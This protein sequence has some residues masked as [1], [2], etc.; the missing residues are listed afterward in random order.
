MGRS[1]A[2]VVSAH[3]VLSP[4]SRVA[5]RDGGRL[6]VMAVE[7]RLLTPALSSSDPPTSDF[8]ATDEERENYFVGRLPGV[9]RASQP[10]AIFFC[11][12]GASVS[13]FARTNQSGFIADVYQGELRGLEKVHATQDQASSANKAEQ[14]SQQRHRMNPSTIGE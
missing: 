14:Q 7:I 12:V 1:Q 9:A 10:R 4:A 3:V 5:S 6:C 8:G 2:K 13:A 11:S